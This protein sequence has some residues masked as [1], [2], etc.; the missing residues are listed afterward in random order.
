[1]LTNLNEGFCVLEVAD[2]V[3]DQA[4][5]L[6][7]VQNVAPEDAGLAEVV[8]VGGVVPRDVP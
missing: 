8:I 7:V 3:A 5:A 1:M 2:N 6:L 4:L